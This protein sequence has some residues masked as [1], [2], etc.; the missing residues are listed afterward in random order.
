M[1]EPVRYFS[2]PEIFAAASRTESDAGE[3]EVRAF[4]TSELLDS[5]RHH[6][7]ADV[8][9]GAFLSA[10]MDSTSLVGLV[11]DTGLP[12]LQ[13]VT[14]A[15]EEFEGRRDDEAPLAEKVA[16]YYGTKHRT[17]RLERSE[18]SN[19]IEA[20]LDAMDQPSIDG[21]NTYFVSKAAK[22]LGWKVA[23]SGLGG[24]EL[25][26]GYN[27]FVDVP[28]WVRKFRGPSKV[29][30]LGDAF[31][32]GPR[33]YMGGN[34]AAGGNDVPCKPCGAGFVPLGL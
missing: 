17:R 31:S 2:I 15:F 10:G 3:T 8:P 6:M 20:I 32:I 5:V 4:I 18:F 1:S 12:D 29:P 21:V 19:D 28:D 27:T 16:A 13:T 22:E 30:F 7:I 11:A 14:L 34:P 25:F 26:G 9:V 24:D 23:L 33:R